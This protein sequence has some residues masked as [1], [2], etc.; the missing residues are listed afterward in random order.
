MPTSD[1]ETLIEEI[2]ASISAIKHITRSD[3]LSVPFETITRIEALGFDLYN[4]M[5][6]MKSLRG[7]ELEK[8]FIEG[9][10]NR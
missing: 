10:I 7:L 1:V 6:N 4:E 9:K 3:I 8:L 2:R 5:G